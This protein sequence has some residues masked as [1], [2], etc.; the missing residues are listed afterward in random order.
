MNWEI[1]KKGKE[2]SEYKLVFAYQWEVKTDRL[3]INAFKKLK[4]KTIIKRKPIQLKKPIQW[5][6]VPYEGIR[7]DK[8]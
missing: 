3:I 5:E 6:S 2:Y 4:N 1:P 7:C 8:Y